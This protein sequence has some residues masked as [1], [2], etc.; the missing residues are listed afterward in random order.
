MIAVDAGRAAALARLFAWDAPFLPR[1]ES[2]HPGDG[3]VRI[4]L[5]AP[6]AALDEVVRW[7]RPQR[8]A[9]AVQMVAASAFL[10]ERGWL[11]S[12]SLLRGC[13]VARREGQPWLR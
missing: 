8:A 2:V 5:A 6:G 4:A 13:R 11:S 1:V 3:V 9:V 7:S 10:L 12:G